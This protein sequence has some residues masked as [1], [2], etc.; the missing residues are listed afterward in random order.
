LTK[1]NFVGRDPSLENVKFNSI[2]FTNVRCDSA[3]AQR[4]GG[5]SASLR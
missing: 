3:N 5:G 2:K 4:D 1:F